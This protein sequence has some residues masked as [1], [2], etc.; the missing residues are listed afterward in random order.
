MPSIDRRKPFKAALA[1]L[2]ETQTA[3]AEKHDVTLQHLQLVAKGG[4]DSIPLEAAID[5]LIARAEHVTA[6]PAAASRPTA[7]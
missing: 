3:F 7:A 6:M 4:R 1:A 5:E 2:G